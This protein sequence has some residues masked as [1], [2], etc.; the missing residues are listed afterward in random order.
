MNS[1]TAQNAGLVAF[2][3]LSGYDKIGLR[4]MVLYF[5]KIKTMTGDEIKDAKELEFAVFCIENT[6]LELDKDPADVYHTLKDRGILYEYVVPSYDALHT[7]GREYIV[8]DII[9]L[10]NERGVTV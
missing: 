4:V 10:M 1:S 3:I 6:A 8:E 5:R 9:S 2:F 7:Q